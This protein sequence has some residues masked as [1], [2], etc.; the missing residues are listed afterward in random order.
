MGC[1]GRFLFGDWTKNV[2][3]INLISLGFSQGG[4]WITFE[5]WGPPFRGL[6]PFLVLAFIPPGRYPSPFYGAREFEGF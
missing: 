6:F 4:G 1:L 5:A 3:G 2:F